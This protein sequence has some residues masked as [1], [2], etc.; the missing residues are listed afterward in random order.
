M[1]GV[2]RPTASE[3][4]GEWARRVRAN[5]EQ[6]ERVREAPE[7]ADF[8]APVA[9]VF[10]ADPRRTDEPVLDLLRAMVEPNDLWLDIG[11]GG[12]RY[13]LPIALAARE[14]IAVDVSDAMLKVL[15]DGAVKNGIENVRIVR[16]RWP[17]KEPIQA[18]VSLISH[19]GYD[20]EEIGPFLDAME[21]ATRRTCVAVL[22][23]ESPAQV[24]ARF[25]PRIHGEEREPLPALAEFLSLLLAR[26]HFFDL[27][28]LTRPTQG[29]AT[30]EAA[31]AFFRQQLFIEP[32]GAKDKQ[33]QAILASELEE[34]DGRYALLAGDIPLGVVTWRP[35]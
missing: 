13:A 10:A 28:M 16:S 7:R 4:L 9:Q 31:G 8:Y 32:G 34:R 21:A 26:G 23:A 29:Y 19:V 11:A 2:L 30:L 12:G 1:V 33:L 22:L 20:I 15:Q 6:A 14:V 25:W 17:A 5:R 35:R 24:A 3:A 18:D 27:K